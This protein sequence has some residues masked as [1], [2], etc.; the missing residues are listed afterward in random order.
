MNRTCTLL[1]FALLAAG[2]SGHRPIR[3]P[4]KDWTITV[5]FNYDFTNFPQCSATV[6]KGCVNGF[7]WGYLQGTTQIPLKT[8]PVSVCTGATQ[9]EAC[10]DSANALLGIGT[11]VYYAQANGIDNNGNAVSSALDQSAPDNIVIGVPAGL[12]GTRQ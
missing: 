1:V 6:T 12:R 10:T 3:P 8:S 11:V 2:C 5:T 4:V 7:T 9:P